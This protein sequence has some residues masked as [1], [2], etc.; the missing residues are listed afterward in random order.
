MCIERQASLDEDALERLA[1]EKAQ[2]RA[3][4]AAR[5]TERAEKRRK[6]QEPAAATA[7]MAKANSATHGVMARWLARGS[8]HTAA[9]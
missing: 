1:I 8:G 2:Q 3:R 4:D 9:A 5:E 7:P 6:A